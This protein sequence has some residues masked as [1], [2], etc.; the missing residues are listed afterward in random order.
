MKRAILAVMVLVAATAG[1]GVLTRAP[2]AEANSHTFTVTRNCFNNTTGTITMTFA[3]ENFTDDST[4]QIRDEQ[5]PNKPPYLVGTNKSGDFSLQVT[6][7]AK[8]AGYHSFR[9]ED[10][11]L[12]VREANIKVPCPRITISPGCGPAATG[13]GETYEIKIT[14]TNFPPLQAEDSIEAVI[15]FDGVQVGPSVGIDEFGS[16]STTVKVPRKSSSYQVAATDTRDSMTATAVFLVPCLSIGTTSTSTTAT[17][18][19]PTTTTVTTTPPTVG[20]V[21]TCVLEPPV[22]PPGF[23]TSANCA[24]FPANADVT[25]R[26]APGLG[27]GTAKADGSGRFRAPMLIFPRDVLG[28]REFIAEAPGVSVR[29]P[30]LV[31]PP[32][33]SPSGGDVATRIRPSLVIRY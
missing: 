4:I 13:S 7:P 20:P 26:W 18:A 33:V 15:T 32:S 6:M 8:P 25:M 29:I 5:Q 27:A 31:V 21:A 23:V 2:H 9:A 1:V 30:F 11:V 3:G 17:T 16:F 12:P 22:G 19:P 24:G 14:G 28:H 10:P